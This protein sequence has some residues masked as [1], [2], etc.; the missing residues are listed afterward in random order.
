MPVEQRKPYTFPVNKIIENFSLNRED[1]LMVDDLKIGYDMANNAK[2]DF[3][4]AGWS[5]SF[6]EIKHFMKK[7]ST[8]YCTQID[9]LEKIVFLR[10]G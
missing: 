9:E 6:D 10:K 4:C 8:Y 3:A 2:I 7:N 1:L 5:H